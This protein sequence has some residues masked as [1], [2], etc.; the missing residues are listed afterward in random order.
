MS[1]EIIDNIIKDLK[2]TFKELVFDEKKHQYKVKGKKLVSVTTYIKNYCKPF[3]E[4]FMADA[5][6]KKWN[7]ENPKNKK[8]ALTFRKEWSKKKNDACDFGTGVHSYAEQ[9]PNFNEPKDNHEL[10]IKEWFSNLDTNRYK[11]VFS[12]FRVYDYKQGKAGTMDLLLYDVETNTLV[13]ADWKTNAKNLLQ[14]YNGAKLLEPFNNLY[15]NS[16][17]HY[18]LQLSQ[19]Q[20]IIESNTKYKVSQRWVIWLKEGQWNVLDEGKTSPKYKI[21]IQ[22]PT[23]ETTY[24]KQ[25]NVEDYSH[26]LT[27]N[28]AN[29]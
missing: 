9:Y 18:K 10:G 11:V 4:K 13:I 2:E 29:E 28:V 26:I 17:N 15:D 12:E 24:Y 6:A 21:D 23:I 19:Y 27:N 22:P 16:L 7:K 25:F 3:D 14:I 8:S 5:C 1:I 20:S